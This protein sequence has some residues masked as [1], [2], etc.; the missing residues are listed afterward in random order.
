MQFDL[1][2]KTKNKFLMGLKVIERLKPIP[3]AGVAQAERPG[4][5]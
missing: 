5:L 1:K 3:S 2:T 4:R